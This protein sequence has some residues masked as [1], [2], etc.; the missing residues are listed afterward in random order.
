MDE[1]NILVESQRIHKANAVAVFSRWQWEKMKLERELKKTER[2]TQESQTEVRVKE[3]R[4]LEPT[5]TKHI[6][7]LFVSRILSCG[8]SR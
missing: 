2:K 4:E 7:G 5:V 3:L 1:S 6:I 8:K